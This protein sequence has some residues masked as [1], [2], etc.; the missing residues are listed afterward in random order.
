MSIS[1]EINAI[2]KDTAT[3][4]SKLTLFGL[5]TGVDGLDALA[6]AVDS[7]EYRGNINANVKE[8]ETYNIPKGYHD[9]SGTVAGVSGGGNYNLQT[10][11]VTPT[12]KQQEVTS[13][14]GYY[15]LSSVT[16]KAI[17]DNY[18]D[19]SNVTAEEGDVLTGKTIVTGE[20]LIKTGTMPNNSAVEKT[21]TPSETDYIIPEGY[22]NGEGYVK[23][24][25]ETK[26]VTPTKSLQT[27][28]PTAGKVISSVTVQAI[29]ESFIETDDADAVESDILL[30]K[31]AYV[32][33]VK[34]TGTMANNGSMDKSFDGMTMTEVNIPEGYT[35]GGTISLT[36]SIEKALAEIRGV[37]V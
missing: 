24:V 14:D 26:D 2:R 19:I 10:K 30:D 20:G 13:D 15:G 16:V 11:E 31:T 27:I 34:V 18:Q 8:G 37:E 33:G 23:I 7:I 12:K 17:P 3:I 4:R 9:G 35:S 25:T 32:N 36:D 29:P 5:A 28:S 6:T 21:L 1:T 22:H